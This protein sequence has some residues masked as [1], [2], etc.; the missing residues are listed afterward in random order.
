RELPALQSILGDI[1]GSIDKKVNPGPSVAKITVEEVAGREYKLIDFYLP[2]MI[3]FSLIGSAVFGVSFLF[4][5][6]RETLVL[7]RLY[8]SPIQK[9]YIILGETLSRIIFQLFTVIVLIG[10]GKFFYNFTLSNGFITF[11]EM[12]FVSTLGL[13]VFMGAGF[14]ISGF[15]KNQNV[16]PIYS[17]LFM[18]P[19]YFLSGTFFPKGALH[20]RH[21]ADADAGACASPAADPDDHPQDLP[22]ALAR[23]AAVG[24]DPGRRAVAASRA[25]RAGD[26]PHGAALAAVLDDLRARL[27]GHAVQ[28]MGD[29]PAAMAVAA[30]R[31]ARAAAQADQQ[32]DRARLFGRAVFLRLGAQ[33]RD[34][35]R[36]AVRRDQGRVDPVGG[37]R[38]CLHAR[39]RAGQLG[40]ARRVASRHGCEGDDGV[41][42]E[43]GGPVARH[44][45]PAQE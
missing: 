5:N 14:V 37:R 27:S 23:A 43:H 16:I 33:A 6:L 13:V 20:E 34:D 21:A 32:R 28:R 19:Q 22:L 18:F 7:K 41:G 17:N 36:Y 29:L 30:K 31:H 38:Q 10:F 26:A 24:G 40:G 42:G 44:A 15:A 8:A 3:G 39:A 45:R 12:L 2:G 35:G 1:I 25:R 9:K 4:F 11:L